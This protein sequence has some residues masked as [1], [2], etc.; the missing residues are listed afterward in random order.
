MLLLPLTLFTCLALLPKSYA[1]DNDATTCDINNNQLQVGTFQLTSDCNSTS[2]CQPS[3]G[4]CLARGCKK[5]DFPLGYAIGEA[6]PKKCG[7]GFFCPDEADACQAVMPVGSAC[8]LNRDDECE[9]PPNF[10]DLRDP[11]GYRNTNGSVCLNFQCMWA[12]RTLGTT[13]VTEQMAYIS[14]ASDDTEFIYVS[15][16][17][18]CRL[19]LYCNA[20]DK[21]CMKQKDF[22]VQC[23]ADKECSSNNCLEDLTCGNRPNQPTHFG[24]WVYIVVGLGILIGVGGTFIGLYLLHRKAR[25]EER[26]KRVQYW[27]EQNAFRQNILQMRE[28]AKASLLSLSMQGNDTPRSTYYAQTGSED[29]SIPMLRRNSGFRTASDDGQDSV[30]HGETPII[31]PADQEGYGWGQRLPAGRRPSQGRKF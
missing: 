20:N 23:S 25:D 29:S 12:N 4:K 8:Q 9:G 16:R 27:R 22:G 7:V 28:T 2:Y 6:T 1:E 21:V 3:T 15:S 14:Y 24:I 13:C 26:E 17:D 30:I 10:A 19:G 31:M 5:D 11:T 18:N